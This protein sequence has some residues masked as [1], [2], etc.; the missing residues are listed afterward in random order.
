MRDFDFYEFAGIVVPGAIALVGISMLFPSAQRL[1]GPEAISVAGLGLFLML[2]YAAGH[3]VQAVGNLL[4]SAWWK[5]CGGMPT[6][7]VTKPD[8]ELLATAQIRMLERRMQALTGT[9]QSVVGTERKDWYPLVRQI[10]AAV[11]AAG[12]A[13]RVDTFN[14]SYGLNRG[15]ASALIVVGAALLFLKGFGEWRVALLI[16][17]GVA[18][19]IY[20][21]HR[22][23]RHY[24]RELFVQFLAL[25]SRSAQEGEDE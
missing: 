23:G 25:P 19:A 24:A 18:V 6:D 4:E 2:A 7:W 12:R 10:Y 20:R 22:F 3:L 16:V 8:Q 13:G 5:L 11:S 9:T 21:M 14:G 1:F 17:A 15:I